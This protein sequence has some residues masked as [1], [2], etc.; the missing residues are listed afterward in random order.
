MSLHEAQ[1]IP[2]ERKRIQVVT[3]ASQLENLLGGH[4]T[5]GAVYVSGES[6][7]TTQVPNAPSKN[8]TP[9]ATAGRS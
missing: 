2:P 4:V 9:A 3:S 7:I 6:P 5:Q 1:P 8:M